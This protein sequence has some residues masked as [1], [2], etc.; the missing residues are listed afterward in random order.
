MQK[1]HSL[2]HAS[3][4]AILLM[5]LAGCGENAHKP[6]ADGEYRSVI[7]LWP[8]HHLIDTLEE[9]LVKAFRKYPQACDEVWFCC[10]DEYTI[11]SAER[12]GRRDKMAKAAED[13]RSLGIIPSLQ[14]VT[15][16]H[17]N[18]EA[19]ASAVNQFGYRAMT[20]ADGVHARTQTCPRDTAFLNMQAEY[21]AYYSEAFQPDNIF[22]DD[23][24][25]VTQHYPVESLCF[26]DHCIGEFNSEFGYSYTRESLVEALVA[27]VPGVRQ[28]WVSFSQ[29]SL[30]MV[31]RYIAREVH[32]VSPETHLGLQHV[33]FH[34]NLLEGWDWNKFFDAVEEETGNTPVSRPGHGFYNDHSP[35][36][37]FEKAYG[38]SRQVARL[39]P[40]IT[41]IAPEIEGYIHKATGKSPQS[42]CTETLLYLGMGA[43][44]MSYAIICGNNEPM[45][46]YADN[47]FKALDKYHSLFKDYVAH[48]KGTL[49][50]GI[51]SYISRNHINRD[52]RPGESPWAWTSTK[53]GDEIMELAP[54]G[55]P[56]T[57]EGGMTTATVLDA[58]ALLGMCDDEVVELLSRTGAVMDAA[59]WAELSSRSIASQ[60]KPVEVHEGLS[61]VTCYQSAAGKRIAV[62][63]AFTGD[64]NNAGRVNTLKV[65][66]WVSEGRMAAVLESMAQAVV[67]PRVTSEGSLKSVIFLNA[68]ISEIPGAT[69]R[70][71]S[72]PSGSR[73]V[74]KSGGNRD[75]R[76]KAVKDGDDYIV[77]IPAVKAWDAGW[78]KVD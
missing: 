40:S 10:E 63:P 26:C 46:W 45:E 78:I 47:Y 1:R 44:S 57:P 33:N 54:L 31:G 7:R 15:I 65:Y 27:N 73:F 53:A 29:A 48:N 34:F 22:I 5:A 19:C 37:M 70:L 36:G 12:A 42:L 74:W 41:L 35:R 64:V 8:S 66:D 62:M 68:T 25:R 21:H 9:N 30:A 67:V 24:L 69:L 4:A 6:V 58:A 43:T 76:L 28:N 77:T 72:C 71:R 61:N 55:I 13:M 17:P 39:S 56:F 59:A 18:Q 50:G 38:I 75:V 60:F 20:G 52:V 23:D 32:K 51:D 14:T 49:G 16:G 2:I 11:D 3:A